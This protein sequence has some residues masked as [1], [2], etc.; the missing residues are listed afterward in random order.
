[1]DDTTIIK[2]QNLFPEDHKYITFLK[3][4]FRHEFRKNGFRRISTT[5][6]DSKD[7]FEKIF[8]EKIAQKT[9]MMNYNWEEIVLTPLASILNLKAYITGNKKEEIQP[10]YNYY[11]ETYYPKNDNNIKAKLLFGWEVIWENDAI[12]DVQNLFIVKHTLD[13]I[14]LKDKYEIK[15]NYIWTKK[16]IDKYKE[17]LSDFYSDKEHLLS[18]ETKEKIKENILN[19]MLPTNEDEEI[20]LQKAPKIE[21]SYKKNSKKEIEKLK[22]YLEI[23][24]ID[25]KLDPFLFGDYEF[26]DGVIWEINLKETKENIA[27][28]YWYNEL[29]NLFWE[30]KEIPASWFYIDILKLVELL[31]EQN[32][33]IKNKDK[34][35][36]FFVQLGDEA[37]K[38]VL[39]LSM[40][41]R[42][43]WINTAVSLGTPSMKEQMLKAQRSKANYVV[44][45]GLMEARNG[46]FQVRN[47]EDWT[48]KEV[49]KEDL[50]NY[51]IDKIW[52]NA[53]DFYEPSKDLLEE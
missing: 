35:D 7:F 23:L 43:A 30:A 49:K 4:V 51:I 19:V 47:M 14:W 11:M 36:L 41:A 37:K 50:I 33:K 13:K 17:K 42:E 52:T 29:S 18:E 21:K 40:K 26:N 9:I 44:M 12:I 34:L 28:W 1:M 3:K 16:E 38:V 2:T 5:I 6:F 53:L 27:K 48:Q 31:K 20:L 25:Y 46:I 32:L 45:V 10:V 15:L 8:W 22:D 24:K 39:P